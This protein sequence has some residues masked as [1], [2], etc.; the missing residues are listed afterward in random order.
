M[1]MST[2]PSQ[3]LAVW[4]VGCI[5]RRGVSCF[6]EQVSTGIAFFWVLVFTIK[7]CIGIDVTTNYVDQEIIQPPIPPVSG[8]ESPRPGNKSQVNN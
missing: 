3:F 1:V 6:A 7:Y 4:V 8:A 2:R 5:V